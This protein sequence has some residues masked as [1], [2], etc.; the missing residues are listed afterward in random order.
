VL[1]RPGE[2]TILQ[3]MELDERRKCQPRNLRDFFAGSII[4]LAPTFAGRVMMG[5]VKDPV[6]RVL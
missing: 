5:A 6:R 2:V 3:A 1:A 4:C